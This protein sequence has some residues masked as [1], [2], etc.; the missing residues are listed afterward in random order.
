MLFSIVSAFKIGVDILCAHQ[1]T[2]EK[3]ALT[4]ASNA[5]ESV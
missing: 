3:I 5:L 4:I 2:N 1:L